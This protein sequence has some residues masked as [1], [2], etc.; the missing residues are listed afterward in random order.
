MRRTKRAAFSRSQA[1]FLNA[2]F[3][4][5][6]ERGHASLTN[7]LSSRPAF[8]SRRI[9][10]DGKI[11]V[12]SSKER[13]YVTR[14]LEAVR[15]DTAHIFDKSDHADDGCGQNAAPFRF[16]IERDIAGDDRSIEG[17][18]CFTHAVYHLRERPHDFGAFGR[19]EVEAIGDGDGACP[20][21]DDAAR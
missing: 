10:A 11:V 12:G 15:H 20:D 14:L 5:K 13:D 21:A 16:V 4:L 6:I 2:L 3:K 1:S 19:S 17:P 9:L 7:H 18:A 8:D